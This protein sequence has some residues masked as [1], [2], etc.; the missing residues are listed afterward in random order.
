MKPRSLALNLADRDKL[1]SILGMTGS[2]P[3]GEALKAARMADQFIRQ[4]GIPW[5]DLLTA[6][7]SDQGSRPRPSTDDPLMRFPTCEAA[8]AFALAGT[9]LLAAWEV[10][11]LRNVPG[12]TKLSAKQLDTLRKLVAHGL[13]AGGAS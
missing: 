6:A 11:F 10:G 13:A 5:T 4:R 9:P 3:D 8:C 12:F 1:A 2:A 7:P